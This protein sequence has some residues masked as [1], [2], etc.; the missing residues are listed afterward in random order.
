MAQKRLFTDPYLAY[1]D[2]ANALDKAVRETLEAFHQAHPDL[3]LRDATT[4]ASQAV[5][6]YYAERVILRSHRLRSASKAT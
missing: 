2:E 5:G 3:D 1:T 4:V 6:T